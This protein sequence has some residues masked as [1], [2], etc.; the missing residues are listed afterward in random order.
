MVLLTISVVTEN[1]DLS[2]LTLTIPLKRAR[3]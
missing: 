3:K 2:F 1:V